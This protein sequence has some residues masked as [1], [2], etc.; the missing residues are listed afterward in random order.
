MVGP[1]SLPR[2]PVRPP[3]GC[4]AQ[5]GACTLDSPDPTAPTMPR[6]ATKGSMRDQAIDEPLRCPRRGSWPS[7]WSLALLVLLPARRLQLAGLSSRVIG[8]YAIGLWLFAM[9]VAIRPI[10]ARFVVPILILAYLAP[11][12]A[13]PER[14]G[15]FLTRGRGGRGPSRPRARTA[16]R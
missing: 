15:R 4:A 1:P 16:D 2:D 13:A 7:G 11:F 9:A 6:D 14:V 5:D 12:V 3:A 8:A 10:A